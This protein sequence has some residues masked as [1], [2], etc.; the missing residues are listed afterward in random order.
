MLSLSYSSAVSSPLYSKSLS[1]ILSHNWFLH[2]GKH[3]SAFELTGIQGLLGHK[4]HIR[5][6]LPNPVATIEPWWTSTY[7]CSHQNLCALSLTQQTK[8][9]PCWSLSNC[10]SHHSTT[11]FSVYPY[12]HHIKLCVLSLLRWPQKPPLLSSS[13][14]C[15]H[16][17]TLVVPNLPLNPSQQQLCP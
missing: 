5:R 11:V 13:D 15:S 9:P 8:K 16:H 7:P 2:A 17:S 3:F 6:P 14:P 1:I 4:S 12:S 10:C